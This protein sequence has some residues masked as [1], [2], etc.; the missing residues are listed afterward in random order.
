M[1]ASVKTDDGPSIG[2]SGSRRMRKSLGKRHD[3]ASVS[4]RWGGHIA[5][6]PPQ[7]CR[8][9]FWGETLG[10]VNERT[11]VGCRQGT[12]V[13]SRFGSLSLPHPHPRRLTSSQKTHPTNKKNVIKTINGKAQRPFSLSSPPSPSPSSFPLSLPLLR[14][15]KHLLHDPTS[16]QYLSPFPK[17]KRSTVRSRYGTKLCRK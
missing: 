2:L 7:G 6:P 3:V 14:L 15:T 1:V 10:R 8:D 13:S 16:S 4:S 11:N 12:R 9:F 17:K 5:F